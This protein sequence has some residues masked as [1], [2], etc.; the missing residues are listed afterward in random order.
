MLV[1]AIVRAAH[2]CLRGGSRIPTRKM[3]SH[4]PQWEDKAGNCPAQQ[5]A[6]GGNLMKRA[7]VV[8]ANTLFFDENRAI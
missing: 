2:L 5:A 4:L 8:P 3:F 7:D 1:C 6:A